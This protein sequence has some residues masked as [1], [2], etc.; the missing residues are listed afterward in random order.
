MSCSSRRS[1]TAQSKPFS[2]PSQLRLSTGARRH[3]S[4]RF[5][6]QSIDSRGVS[7]RTSFVL[8]TS[9]FSVLVRMMLALVLSPFAIVFAV[10]VALTRRAAFRLRD[11]TQKRLPL[12]SDGII[13]GARGFD[14]PRGASAPAVLLIHGGGDTPQTL[15]YLADY[16]YQRGYH[17]RAP[18]LPGHGRTPRAF[19]NVLADQWMETVRDAYRELSGEHSWVAVAG[20]SMGGALAAQLAAEQGSVP[21]VVLLAPYLA[22]PTRIALAARSASLWRF[23]VPY[24][25]A[26]DPAARRS[27]QDEREAARSLAYGIFTPAALRALRKTVACGDPRAAQNRVSNADGAVARRQPNSTR[28]GATGLRSHWRRRQETRVADRSRPR[29]H[30]RLRTRSRVRGCRRLARRSPCPYRSR[31]T[32]AN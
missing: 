7:A 18:L 20:L 14:L 17:V 27:I 29:D 12:D 9:S 30:R 2:K 32:R 16:L 15:R 22:L 10:L 28:R 24:V 3:S 19:S 5:C 25:R 23:A 1:R 31:A 21:A 13:I 11:D 4:P 6:G 26:L 8:R